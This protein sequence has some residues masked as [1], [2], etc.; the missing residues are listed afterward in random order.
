MVAIPSHNGQ[1][2][3][4]CAGGVA[5]CVAGCRFGNFYFHVQGSCINHIRNQIAGI[6]L[7]A[8]QFDILVCIDADIGFTQQDFDYL[9]EGSEDIATAE[10]CRKHED[11]VPVTFGMG[12]VRI[13]RRVFEALDNLLDDAGNPLVGTYY[14]GPNME[15]DYFRTGASSDSRWMAEDFGFWSLVHLAGIKPKVE[16]RTRLNHWGLKAYKYRPDAE[17]GA[18]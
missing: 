16:K 13:H 4:E 9:M 7:R 1:I 3:V 15:R 17:F 10:Y 14:E 11:Y 12:F 2:F 18:Q 6:F 5:H 8:T